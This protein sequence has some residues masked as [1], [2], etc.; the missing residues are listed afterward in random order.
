MEN[1]IKEL[2]EANIEE[3]DKLYEF[4][5]LANLLNEQYVLDWLDRLNKISVR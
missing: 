4:L 2:L 3:L 5:E 1:A